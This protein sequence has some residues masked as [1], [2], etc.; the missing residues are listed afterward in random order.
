MKKKKAWGVI[1]GQ[2]YRIPPPK[3]VDLALLKSFD[4][5]KDASSLRLELKTPVLLGKLADVKVPSRYWVRLSCYSAGKGLKYSGKA[6]PA[7]G[8][9]ARLP[10]NF[11]ELK[12]VNV[13]A[14]NKFRQAWGKR[15]S[16]GFWADSKAYERD[17]LPK[18]KSLI[19][20]RK[21]KPAAFYSLLEYQPPKGKKY[22]L[23]AWH[24]P[25]G[26]LSPAERRSVWHQAS[27]W[28][29]KTA[30]HQLGVGLDGFDKESIEFFSRLG[31]R[32]TR[33]RFERL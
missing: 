16:K 22:S 24:N 25:L 9:E 19:M 33:L 1:E 23:V 20:F 10:K 12:R 6:V 18:T 14:H 3:R 28:L 4:W 27:L 29:S 7:A 30:K 11:A 5:P 17:Y 26:R 15:M 13:M 2:V 31:F 8:I 21:G 32:V